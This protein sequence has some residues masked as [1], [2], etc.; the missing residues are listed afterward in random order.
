VAFDIAAHA[1]GHCDLSCAP[2]DL[3]SFCASGESLGG[4]TTGCVPDDAPR[5]RT[6]AT[7]TRCQIPIESRSRH[8]CRC[9]RGQPAALQDEVR[10]AHS[11]PA[12]PR[13]SRSACGYYHVPLRAAS[14]VPVF[15]KPLHGLILGQHARAQP[16]AFDRCDVTRCGCY[17]DQ[18]PVGL[19]PDDEYNSDRPAIFFTDSRNAL[20]VLH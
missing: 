5:G 12:P 3:R 19:E 1:D 2:V 6:C 14:C 9:W 17:P 16:R 4:L 15:A 10:P 8:S 20:A 13:G 7:W 11:Q 18:S